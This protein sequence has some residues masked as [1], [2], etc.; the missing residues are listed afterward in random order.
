M[1]DNLLFPC[2]SVSFLFTINPFCPKNIIGILC[3]LSRS[4]QNRHEV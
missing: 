2:F 1:F 4:V 3:R